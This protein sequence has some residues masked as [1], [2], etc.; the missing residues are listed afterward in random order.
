[1]QANVIESY[2]HE[3]PETISKPHLPSNPLVGQCLFSHN[4]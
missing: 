1:M 2:I 4:Q 3:P